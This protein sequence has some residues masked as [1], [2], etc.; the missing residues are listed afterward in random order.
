MMFVGRIAVAPI[1][2]LY[3]SVIVMLLLV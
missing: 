1:Y 3:Y 2:S